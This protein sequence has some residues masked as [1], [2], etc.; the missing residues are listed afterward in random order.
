M[1]RSFKLPPKV[2]LPSP[3]SRLERDCF[4]RW[5]AQALAFWEY[6]CGATTQMACSMPH[7]R[8][9]TSV[10]CDPE[11]AKTVSDVCP[12]ATVVFVDV[13]NVD[14]NGWPIQPAFQQFWSQYS[15]IWSQSEKVYDTVLLAG[16]FRLACA[17]WMCLHPRGVKQMLLAN[18]VDRPD[19]HALEEF[20]DIVEVVDRL[21]VVR[22]KRVF[23]RQ[24][25]EALYEQSK[26]NP[27]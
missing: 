19:Y 1:D 13:G 7:L 17:L 2:K 27:S 20:V 16:R 22:P 6:G 15:Q 10:E 26:T 14:E 23:N 18:F 11:Y 9:I 25:C 8:D 4:Q 12:K 24:R 21:A 5:L 3:F